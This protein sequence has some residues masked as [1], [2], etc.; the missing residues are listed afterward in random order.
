MPHDMT[1]FYIE[2]RKKLR[3]HNVFVID[4]HVPSEG[5]F[6]EGAFIFLTNPRQ[7]SPRDFLFANRLQ[8]HFI[9]VHLLDDKTETQ[10][11]TPLYVFLNHPDARDNLFDISRF[12]GPSA[13]LWIL[14]F[15]SSGKP[16]SIQSVASRLDWLS[17]SPTQRRFKCGNVRCFFKKL[18]DYW[19]Q[20]ML[21][22][23]I[24]LYQTNKPENKLINK[25]L[26]ALVSLA[27]GE[28]ARQRRK[29]AFR[30][31]FPFYGTQDN[32]FSYAKKA[33]RLRYLVTA[34]DIGRITD[35]AVRALHIATIAQVAANFVHAGDPDSYFIVLDELIIFGGTENKP[36][37]YRQITPEGLKNLDK[38]MPLLSWHLLARIPNQS[39]IGCMD[40]ILAENRPEIVSRL[41]YLIA[42]LE[43]LINRLALANASN[44]WAFKRDREFCAIW[45]T[46]A[47][48]NLYCHARLKK[49]KTALEKARKFARHSLG[50][51]HKDEKLRNFNTLMACEC[52]ALV[53][54]PDT[55][56][57]ACFTDQARGFQE[58][59]KL[60]KQPLQSYNL[61]FAL[62]TALTGHAKIKGFDPIDYLEGTGLN[63]IDAF[64]VEPIP[65]NHYAQGLI[66]AY[67]L[68]LAAANQRVY[69]KTQN[70][71][72][73]MVRETRNFF[74]HQEGILKMIC[75]KFLISHSHYLNVT[76]RSKSG[77]IDSY[78]R[79]VEHSP[80]EESLKR[81][82][83]DAFKNTQSSL[84]QTLELIFRLPY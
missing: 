45:G 51:A 77:V 15:K 36:V 21:L 19:R 72:E 11:F 8:L 81:D 80:L 47:Q 83:C 65:Q 25:L 17:E 4:N 2:D 26:D 73:A 12:A 56:N 67:C 43:W 24:H 32:R 66:Y 10:K 9:E 42:N 48:F 39:V 69:L 18:P 78:S 41:L 28:E 75:I 53:L 62:L 44:P 79:I 20:A 7:F 49:D 40:I 1:S 29:S 55:D 60:E 76:G 33:S 52:T 31:V 64:K 84:A 46:L 50:Y 27:P 14:K 74:I 63:L 82:I 70:R 13:S 16:G 5:D 23:D 22:D 38:I 71:L 34:L 35:R 6:P 30:D 68:L 59:L 3:P 54:F 61:M 58:S 37:G 57:E